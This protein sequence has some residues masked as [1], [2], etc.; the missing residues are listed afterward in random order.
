MNVSLSR[1]AAVHPGQQAEG[2]HVLGALAVLLRRAD[3]LDGAERQR[4]HRHR[5]YDVV[6]EVVVFQRVGVVADLGEIA[7][8]ELVGVGDDQPATGKVGDIGLQ[9][10]RVHRDKDVG[11][12]ARG[13]DVVV[14]DL[15]LERRNAGQCAL[16]GA[17]LGWVIGL[18]RKVVAEKRRFRGEPV[19]GELHAVT[20]V[21]REPDDDLFKLLPGARWLRC[22]SHPLPAFRFLYQSSPGESAGRSPGDAPSVHV[23]QSLMSLAVPIIALS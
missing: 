18:G 22:R 12:V 5:L 20:G 21:A 13:Q 10:C 6:G 2:E 9:R 16:W 17:D 4:R 8:G 15:N 1:S 19:A 23:R 14:G 11:T 7:L 3:R